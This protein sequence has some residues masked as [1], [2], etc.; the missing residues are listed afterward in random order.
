MRI[1]F[2]K[3]NIKNFKG[4]RDLTIEFNGTLTNILGANHTG[5]TTTADAIHWVLFGKSSDGLTVF[6]IDPKDEDNQVIHHLENSVTLT[7]TADGRE[8]TLQKVRKENWLKPKGHDEEV[9]DSHSTDCYIDGNKYT[10]KDYTAE[11]AK[12]CPESLFRAITNPAYFPGLKADD[13][14]A[15]LVKMVGERTPE[16]IAGGNE[17]FKNLVEKL[18]GEDLKAFRQHLSYQMK[19]LKEEIEKIP[20]RISENQDTLASLTEK[21]VNF[22][23]LRKRLTEVEKGIANYDEQLKDSTA[24]LNQDY[25]RRM[26]Q[27][28]VINRIKGR[29]RDIEDETDRRNRQARREHTNEVGECRSKVE[30]LQRRIQGADREVKDY[31]SQLNSIELRTGKFRKE[32]A[33]VEAEEFRWDDSRETCPTCGQ[34][35]PE[36]DI[37]KM[38]AD[39]EELWS[40]GHARAQDELDQKAVA[41][42]K[43]KEDANASLKEARK[44]KADLEAELKVAQE[45]LD[46]AE[47]QEVKQ[48]TVADSQEYRE[49]KAKLSGEETVLDGMI[50]CAPSDRYA[51]DITGKKATLVK[52]RDEL[53]DQLAVEEQI[54]QRNE[55]IQELQKQLERLNQQLTGLEQEDYQAECLEHAVIEDL[56]TRVNKLFS[57]VRFKMF[58]TQLNGNTKS[59]CVL[60]MHGV[61]YQDLSNSEK[62]NSGIDLINAMNRHTGTYAPITIDNAESVNEVLPSDSQEILLIVSRDKQ[63]TVVA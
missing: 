12:L 2:K 53:R 13:Q 30:S 34:R 26:E 21:G 52:T 46:G 22:D 31:E 8:L 28:R 59:T 6:G 40:D 43:A 58:E 35:L 63:L 41:I 16:E 47:S 49:L 62:I 38:K 48:E 32:W 36:G 51:K 39:A 10:I 20:A 17:D 9:L 19:Q 3:L 24:R 5:K 45:R 18:K 50:D 37:E 15:L 11:I 57:R 29:M 60:T 23:F 7:L 33:E 44:Q 55:R 27:R 42:K 14:R 54:K 56:E 25:D 4:V 1:I 61:P